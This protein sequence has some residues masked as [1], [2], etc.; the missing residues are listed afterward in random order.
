MIH[1]CECKTPE[2]EALWTKVRCPVCGKEEK[3][4]DGVICKKCGNTIVDEKYIPKN[5]EMR[6]KHTLAEYLEKIFGAK[7]TR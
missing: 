5:Q 6:C 3:L 7:T 1:I 2:P 4:F